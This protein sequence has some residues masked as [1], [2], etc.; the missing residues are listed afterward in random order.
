MA[1][2]PIREIPGAIADPIGSDLIAMDNGTQM[3]KTTVKK[4][5]DAGAPLASQAEAQAGT[6]ND[7][8]MSALRT[9]QSISSEV[10]VTIASKVQGDLASTSVQAVNGKTGSSVNL[11]KDDV[12]LSNIDNTSDANKPI[13]T[14]TQN[15]LNLKA[16]TADLGSLATKS[17]VN[18]ADWSGLDLAVENGGTGAST[19]DVARANLG[20][21]ST[22]QAVPSGGTTGQVLAK[23]SN[24]DNAVG[25]ANA[26]AGDMLKSVYDPSNV[27]ANAFDLNNSLNGTL[28]DSKV[29]T[30]PSPSQGIS[31]SKVK[32]QRLNSPFVRA[33]NDK[34]SDYFTPKDYGALGDQTASD[35][36]LADAVSAA[37]AESKTLVI[38]G[39]TPGQWYALTQPMMIDLSSST[40]L[41]D[42]K[43]P[44]IRG[45]SAG[46]SFIRYTGAGPALTVK[47][48]AVQGEGHHSLVSVSDLTF[49]GPGDTTA[50]VFGIQ[51][52][53]QAYFRMDRV[54]IEGFDVALTAIDLEFSKFN[55]CN[56]RYNNAGAYITSRGTGDPTS[57]LPNGNTF[58]NCEI[59]LNRKYGAHVIG[60]CLIGFLNSHFQYNG[61]RG[62]YAPGSTDAWGIR[63]Q[64]AGFQGGVGLNMSGCYVEHNTG[65]ADVWLSSDGFAGGPL[66]NPVVHNIFGNSFSRA[67]RAGTLPNPPAPYHIY[68]SF[69]EAAAGRTLVNVIGNG[70]KYY[71]DY[72][73]NASNKVIAFDPGSSVKMD[74]DHLYEAGNLYMSSVE[75]PDFIGNQSESLITKSKTLPATGWPGQILVNA[76]N[77][78]PY[79]WT[80]TNGT[81]FSW[82]QMTIV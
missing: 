66:I 56:F 73:P 29:F 20:A 65:Q 44:A 43:R 57:S 40:S 75:K 26:G 37:V 51:L 80:S 17:T 62:G 31:L 10:G 54:T 18:N 32:F 53:H 52:D 50:N 6:D 2:I 39:N 49:I 5:V 16:N 33:G 64:N 41:L 12:G 13:S 42:K 36:K 61:I 63:V 14:A 7:K 81:T 77:G 23:T 72:I 34:A 38:P 74:P 28:K 78:V 47:G 19:A 46:T 59:S 9:K 35:N 76:A 30:P 69:N 45:E 82:R 68:G 3:R 11:V 79:I 8:R 48:A 15:A 70:F 60:P 25:W 1:N 55:E 27:N 22:A 58:T 4:V 21:A 67:T 24:A 71:N